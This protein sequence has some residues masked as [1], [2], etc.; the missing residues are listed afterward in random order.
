[1]KKKLKKIII[2]M[3]SLVFIFGNIALV[4]P[5]NI[6]INTSALETDEVLLEDEME[7]GI[8]NTES[9]I[10]ENSVSENEATSGK[11]GD[12][13][14]WEFFE[15]G[16]LK[17]S[18]IG[19]M[20]TVYYE[21]DIPWAGLREEI[22]K[23]II[24]KGVTSIGDYA[25]YDCSNLTSI[26]IP[27]SV[28]EIWNYTFRNCSNLTDITIPDGVTSIGT[29][30]FMN[31]T[32]LTNIIIPDSVTSTGV[33]V[34]WCCN[35]LTNITIS[36]SITSIRENFFRGCISLTSITIPESVTS[37]EDYAFDGCSSLTNITISDGVTFIKSCAFKNCTSLTSITFPESVTYIGQ[38]TFKNCTNLANI[39]LPDTITTLGS[40]AFSYTNLTCVIIPRGVTTIQNHIFEGCNLEKMIIPDSVKRFLQFSFTGCTDFTDI[41]YTGTEEQWAMIERDI[42]YG[43]NLKG[44][45]HYNY[46]G[47]LYNG[48][49]ID[50]KEFIK[51]DKENQKATFS[52]SLYTYGVNENTD[53]SF[54]DSLDS[55]IGQ[56]V[57][58]VT[59][60]EKT[61]VLLGVY[62][63]EKVEGMITS[64]SPSTVT[65]NNVTYLA[66]KDFTHYGSLPVPITKTICYI[67]NNNIV[68]M[69]IGEEK[70]GILEKWNGT[71]NEIT[72]DGNTYPLKTD[73]LSFLTSIQ[74]WM[75][76]SISYVVLDG[77]VVQLNLTS[78][79]SSY[80]GK[81]EKY[82]KNSRLL[83]FSDGKEYYVSNDLKDSVSEYM[84]KWGVYVITTSQENGTEITSISPVKVQ[85]KVTLEISKKT[86]YYKDGKYS[87]DNQNFVDRGEI[88]I[89]YTIKIENSTNANKS[90]WS[91]LKNESEYAITIE[92]LNIEIP[93]NFNFGWLLEGDIQSIKEGTVL[94]IGDV[95]GANGYIRP[96]VGYRPEANTNSYTIES[97]L[98]TS[99]GD[100]SAENTFAITQNYDDSSINELKT[101]ASQ[102]LSEISDKIALV[103]M[104]EY[105]DKDTQDAISE[106]L[107]SVAMMANAEKEDF[108]EAL[109]EELFD[110][111]FG[112]WK[113]KT[114]ANT[115]DIPI[116]IAV[117]TEKYG[118]L[119]FEF[120]MHITSFDLD[121]S[122]YGI[123]GSIDYEIVDG[124]RLN[125]IL[126][127]SKKNAGI[128]SQC[129]VTAFCDSAYNLAEKEIKKAY[130]KIWGD[131]ANKVGNIIFGQTVT[132]I[133]K[134]NDTSYSDIMFKIITAAGKSYTVKC[135]VDVYVYDKSG[136]LCA[137]IVNNKIE[138]N[139]QTDSIHLEVVGDTKIVTL[140]DDNYS[141]K[142][143]SNDTGTM[144]ITVTEYAGMN[145]ILRT[146]EFY[147]LTLGD[148]I[149][150]STDVPQD[151][152]TGE[153]ILV[154]NK[155][156]KIKPAVDTTHL[157][158]IIVDEKPQEHIHEYNNPIFSWSEDYQSCSALFTCK[159]GD[160][161]QNFECVVETF[162]NDD[163][164]IVYKASVEFNGVSYTDTQII[165][166]KDEIDDKEEPSKPSGSGETDTNTSD[167][168]SKGEIDTDNN[169]SDKNGAI[170]NSK[171]KTNN[172]SSSKAV[173]TGDDNMLSPFAGLM[174]LSV[175]IY[176]TIKKRY[177]KKL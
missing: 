135:P 71:T 155:D 95:V 59:D 161:Q 144:D 140:W 173:D 121:G 78:Y 120:T 156:E 48:G 81:L 31:C 118:K 172:N 20:P 69:E 88:L 127:K 53:L 14:T 174:I 54:I 28:T 132:D 84:N 159:D 146:V 44:T 41:Y 145:S 4:N 47:S 62:P 77:N 13:I 165:E 30:A 65:F 153:Y 119:V 7:L 150:Y 25:F 139:T 21:S 56:K 17:F 162:E 177:L 34:F 18:G 103:D 106:A 90:A 93:S 157:E 114:G 98:N 86:L 35:S 29:G 60:P 104:S 168:T 149:Y 138:K 46:N 152:L 83:H 42:Y 3:L 126:I 72:I 171:D 87:Y 33:Q 160:D 97:V 76:K 74:N 147:D 116:K 64:W 154:D 32:S 66:A 102:S 143:D 115:Y 137:S 27:D 22:N 133:L 142:F 109:T 94:H 10:A 131:D 24:D 175:V 158:T 176:I 134:E 96:S 36:N 123:F 99:I 122:R 43:T 136:N 49:N 15:D 113:L 124:E 111:V 80:T 164:T 11:W 73:D 70:S 12:N 92:D 19:D 117:D 39:S 129:D 61:G 37:I 79:Q 55:L 57:L 148:N 23:V 82:D 151:I 67:H 110:K 9:N 52:N 91:Q 101:A 38:D 16:T 169:V 1:M 100:Y 141:L 2:S 128:I 85:C 130:N 167:G 107:L 75:D 163:N 166:N 58:V 63:I 26:T 170:A 40:G 50:V 45:V 89:P 68:G 112:D 108:K 51:W 125:E 6:I 8:D 105:F 5:N